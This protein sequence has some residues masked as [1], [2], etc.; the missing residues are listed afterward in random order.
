[1]KKTYFIIAFNCI[2]M[3]IFCQ[4]TAGTLD[5]SFGTDGK[6]LTM[7]DNFGGSRASLRTN[8]DGIISASGG[9]F[10]SLPSFFMIKYLKDG[11]IEQHLQ[12]KCKPAH[13]WQL[14]Y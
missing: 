10:N 12:F 8:D 4:N 2:S 3:A 5:S 1:M 11:D 6:V 9:L 7:S 13:P 14:Y